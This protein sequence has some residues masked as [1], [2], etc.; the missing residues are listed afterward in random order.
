MQITH[1][2][3]IRVLN[4]WIP[5]FPLLSISQLLDRTRRGM[6]EIEKKVVFP[7]LILMILYYD[8]IIFRIIWTILNMHWRRKW[9]IIFNRL[10]T[11]P[12]KILWRSNHTTKEIYSISDCTRR[13]NCQ[14]KY[15]VQGIY[16]RLNFYFST[17][18]CRKNPEQNLL[19]SSTFVRKKSFA[20]HEKLIGISFHRFRRWKIMQINFFIVYYFKFLIRFE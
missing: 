3:A 1:S 13:T 9:I 5:S 18:Q 19:F 2:A 16:C 17:Q 15:K 20:L 11:F 12:N 10:P 7:L 4:S 8:W 6:I 14:V